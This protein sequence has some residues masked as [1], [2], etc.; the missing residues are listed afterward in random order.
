MFH[1]KFVKFMLWILLPLFLYAQ[2]TSDLES[3]FKYQALVIELKGEARIFRQGQKTGIPVQWGSYIYQGDTVRTTGKSRLKL[4][5]HDGDMI[6]LGGN[7]EMA[8]DTHA[9]KEPDKATTAANEKAKAIPIL[10]SLISISH[11]MSKK[12]IV[13]TANGDLMITSE[14]RSTCEDSFMLFPRNHSIDTLEPTFKWTSSY[15]DEGISYKLTL[16]DNE[17][18]IWEVTTRSKEVKYPANLEWGKT[19]RLRF[20]IERDLRSLTGA[21]F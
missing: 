17:K 11:L 15:R 1:L 12:K 18:K 7:S 6:V 9:G 21:L 16:F 8:I 3:Q 5:F 14:M 2:E 13:S 4:L 20:E 10:D 19:Y